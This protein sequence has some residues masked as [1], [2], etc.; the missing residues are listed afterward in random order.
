MRHR[1][2]LPLAYIATLTGCMSAPPRGAF[3]EYR[4]GETPVT[5]PIKYEA[6]YELRAKD[7]PPD[8]PPLTAHY[9]A[10]G[11]RI[12]FCRASDGSLWAVAPGYSLSLAPG[13]YAWKVVPGSG[14]SDKERFWCEV[15]ENSRVAGRVIL[16]AAGVAV[17]L[18]VV[19]GVLL[20]IA[21]ARSD[22]F[23]FS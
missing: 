13:S 17:L 15:R 10:K 18:V 5:Q 9:L 2:V 12:G 3:V 14:P 22:G 16:I 7:Q 8:T 11:E 19:T 4:E 21:F 23:N 6:T 1:L 20:I